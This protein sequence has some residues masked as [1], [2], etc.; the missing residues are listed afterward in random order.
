[1]SK[2]SSTTQCPR[3]DQP[4]Q[5]I[6]QLMNGYMHDGWDE[7]YSQ[8][9]CF[10]V[11]GGPPLGVTDENLRSPEFLNWKM[12]KKISFRFNFKIK[13][14]AHHVSKINHRNINFHF[15]RIFP[16]IDKLSIRIC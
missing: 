3:D 4:I 12:F 14:S 5:P 15:K 6:H 8:N 9:V 16:I 7:S 10:M 1:M 2:H 13:G 11:S